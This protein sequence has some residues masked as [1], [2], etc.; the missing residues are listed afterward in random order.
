M[1]YFSE[2]TSG[3]TGRRKIRSYVL[4]EGRATK[5]Q[6]K[7]LHKYW[8]EY[9]IDFD[10]HYLDLDAVFGRVA[11]R[12]L[13]IGSGK[14]DT[15]AQIA[16]KYPENDYLAVEVH[17][18]GIGNLLGQLLTQNL[19]NVRIICHDVV[20]ILQYQLPPVCLDKIYIFFPDPWPKKRHHK[21]R[22]LQAHFLNLL[23]TVLKPSGCIF[24]ATDWQHYAEQIIQLLVSDTD[25]INLAGKDNFVHRPTWRPITKFEKQAMD[26]G[27]RIYDFALLLRN[28]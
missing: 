24:I 27:R 19:S 20:E 12:I 21:R 14:G 11:P 3:A 13:E 23:K 1:V 16:A 28:K 17:R 22:L 8:P 7:N 6:K 9:G 26:N 10:Q 2:A 18:P 15:T 5:S 4:R 25:I